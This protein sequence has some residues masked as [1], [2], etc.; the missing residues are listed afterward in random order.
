MK[1]VVRQCVGF[2]LIKLLVVIAILIS[3]LLPAVQQAREVAWRTQCKNNLKQLA[4][5]LHNYESTFTTFPPSQLD[6][7]FEIEDN[8]GMES[9]YQPWTTMSLPVVDQ[10]NLQNLI[11]FN[12][13]RNSLA[14]RPI[15]GTQLAVMKCP[16]A[17]GG[18]R[19]DPDWVT[20]T[21]A[22][23]YGAINEVKKKG[24][25]ERAGSGRSR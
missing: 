14:N 17:P 20:G 5:A 9:N 25:H 10:A 11:D 4:L 24:L 6:P 3:L 16:S 7:K 2:T 21:A 18:S 1:F 23:D 15:V 19:I 13:A 12:T 22:G 8:P